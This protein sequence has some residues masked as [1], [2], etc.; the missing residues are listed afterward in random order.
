MTAIESLQSQGAAGNAYVEK[1]RKSEEYQK[2]LEELRIYERR[3][4]DH[5]AFLC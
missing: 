5:Y 2:T 4:R 3:V 1:L